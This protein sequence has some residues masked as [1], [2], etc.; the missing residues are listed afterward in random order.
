MRYYIF[1]FSLLLWGVVSTHAET[2]LGTIPLDCPDVDPPIF[3]FD[4]TQELIAFMS[5]AEIFNSVEDIYVHTYQKSDEDFDKLGTY[6]EDILSEN[7]WDEFAED[8]NYRI[9]Y[10]VNTD[11]NNEKVVGIFAIIKTNFSIYLLNVVGEIPYQ[12]VGTLLAN[13]NQLG[14][15]IPKIAW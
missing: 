13:L 1:I 3:E 7:G 14:I 5:T 8:V 10:L 12:Q 11:E 2:R 4:L 9:Y 15:W 6:Y